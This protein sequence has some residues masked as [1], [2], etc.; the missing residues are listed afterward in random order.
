MEQSLISE[1]IASIH[2][3]G[4]QFVLAITGGGSGVLGQLLEVPGGSRSL[5]EGLVPYASKSLEEFLGGAPDQYCSERTSRAMAMAAWTRARNLASDADPRS[6]V[7]V[8]V[9][10]SLVS[11]RPKQGE[12][13]IHVAT[14]TALQTTS[15]SLTLIKGSRTR[16]EEESIATR[17]ALLAMA[18]VCGL[19]DKKWQDE[20]QNLPQ[21]TE[22]LELRSM[23]AKPEWTSLLLGESQC[24]SARGNQHAKPAVVFPG[25][26]NPLH[27]GHLRMAKIA[28]ENLCGDLVYEISI[29]NVDKPPLDFVEINDRLSA[30]QSID[31]GR[32]VFLSWAPTFREKAKLVPGSTFVVGIDTLVRIADDKYYHHNP[33]ERDQAIAEIATAGC[34]FLV[35]GRQLDGQFCCLSNVDLPDALRAICDEV[36]AK[37]FREDV[38]SWE[39]RVF[40]KSKMQGGT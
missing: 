17:M 29:A 6:L 30:I 10:A 1:K 28:A 39:L 5:L 37:Q 14:Q 19:N 31:P 8:G 3:S 27:Q 24:V 35:F 22:N 11:D 25:A 4:K 33:S 9:T 23:V 26:F 15:F 34:R 16:R 40:K 38:S 36:P 2:E 21:P 12:H 32:N 18:E 13:R 7:G 20:F